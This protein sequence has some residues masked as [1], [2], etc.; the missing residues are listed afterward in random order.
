M[1]NPGFAR[2]AL[3]GLPMAMTSPVHHDRGIAGRC[4]QADLGKCTVEWASCLSGLLSEVHGGCRVTRKI[5][6]S[7]GDE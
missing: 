5:V 4:G 1:V 7:M 2:R 6:G 3:R